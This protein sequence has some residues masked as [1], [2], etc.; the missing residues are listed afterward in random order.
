MAILWDLLSIVHHLVT[1]NRLDNTGIVHLKSALATLTNLTKLDLSSNQLTAD[2]IKQLAT[3]C[4][5]TQAD[6]KPL[7]VCTCTLVEL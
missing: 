4:D 7:Q 1:G 6:D 2:S 5:D 3:L